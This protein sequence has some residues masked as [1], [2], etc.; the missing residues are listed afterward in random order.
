VKYFNPV[1]NEIEEAASMNFARSSHTCNLLGGGRVIV[2][3]GFNP[4]NGFQQTSCE[5]YDP[6][7][8][9]WQNIAPLNS[10]RDNHAAAVHL[11]GQRLV[12]SGGR[13]YNAELNLFEGQKSV[14]VYNQQTDIVGDLFS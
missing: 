13:Y 6:N 7:T 14:E 11:S 12:V 3:G 2:T 5:M 1:T 4:D 8:N 10:G 9:T